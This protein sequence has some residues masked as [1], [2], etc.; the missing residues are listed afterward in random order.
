[1]K[2]FQLMLCGLCSGMYLFKTVES[3]AL[4]GH[5]LDCIFL[6][7]FYSIGD[8]KRC[9]HPTSLRKLHVYKPDCQLD[10]LSQL[11][12]EC[13]LVNWGTGALLMIDHI[14]GYKKTDLQ[15][16]K[17]DCRK[18]EQQQEVEIKDNLE[19]KKN[20]PLVN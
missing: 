2:T 5:A 11:Q 1:M 18:I 10:D 17:E 3:A 4:F 19:R 16:E 12:E 7:K 20:F 8:A 14:Q 9:P 13:E 15:R 6:V